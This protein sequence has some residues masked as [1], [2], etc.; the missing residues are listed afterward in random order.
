MFMLNFK[1]LIFDHSGLSL[2]LAVLVF[3]LEFPSDSR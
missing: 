2:A 3:T 1:I